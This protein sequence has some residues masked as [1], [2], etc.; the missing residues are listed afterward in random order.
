MNA[1]HLLRPDPGPE[2]SPP[3][4]R[5]TAAAARTLFRDELASPGFGVTAADLPEPASSRGGSGYAVPARTSTSSTRTSRTRGRYSGSVAWSGRSPPDFVALVQYNYAKGEHITRFFDANDSR[6]RLPLGDRARDGGPNGMRAAPPAAAASRASRPRARA[7]TTASPSGSPSASPRTT[8]SRSTTRCPGTSP[9]TTTSATRSRYRYASYTNLDAEYGY[10][11]RDQRHRLNGFFLWHAPGKVNVNL[12]YSYRSAQPLSLSAQR[13][14]VAA[15]S[16]APP[17]TGSAPDGIDRRSATPGAR[18]TTFSSL[19]LRLSREFRLGDRVR[20][21]PIVEV[22]NLFNSKNL[23]AA[24]VRQPGLQLRRH[25]RERPRRAPA[26][27]GRRAARLV[28]ARSRISNP[29]GT[30]VP[31]GPPATGCG[32]PGRRGG[33]PSPRR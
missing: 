7:A 24:Q 21:E 10:S 25:D 4:A 19:D 6:V 14:R 5:R 23:H 27:A 30:T 17:P 2:R 26:D 22:F 8:S 11:D 28:G 15:R 12:R 29:G 3:R 20:L 31:P 33:P 9:T 13:R 16:S 32:R 1:G 18:T